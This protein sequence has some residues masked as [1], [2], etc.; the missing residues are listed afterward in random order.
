MESEAE[1]PVFDIEGFIKHLTDAGMPET[2]ASIVAEQQAR[3][4]TRFHQK[5]LIA[6][7]SKGAVEMATRLFSP[8][9]HS[10]EGRNP[11]LQGC[12]AF[13]EL[14]GSAELTEDRAV[15]ERRLP[16]AGR[17]GTSRRGREAGESRGGRFY[18]KARWVIVPVYYHSCFA[19][20]AY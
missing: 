4:H 3:V 5:R 1:I 20:V 19:G 17:L 11:R 15:I 12:R 18:L 14:S 10:G 9:R 13:G 2:Q 8:R 16:A 7:H 6:K